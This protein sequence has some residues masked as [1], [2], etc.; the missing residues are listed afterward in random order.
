MSYAHM[1]HAVVACAKLKVMSRLQQLI[2]ICIVFL[3]I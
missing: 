1:L 3:F 2:F